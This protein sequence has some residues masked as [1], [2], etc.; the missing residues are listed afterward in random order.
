MEN[1]KDVEENEADRLTSSNSAKEGHPLLAD[2]TTNNSFTNATEPSQ[3]P[4]DISRFYFP[5]ALEGIDTLAKVAAVT[6]RLGMNGPNTLYAQSVCPDEINHEPGDITHLFSTHYGEVFHMGGLAGLP[7]TGKTGFGAFSHHVPKDG[8]CLILMAPHIGI[9]ESNILG[10]YTRDGQ[11]GEGAACGAAVAA[12]HHCACGKPAPSLDDPLDYQ[13]SFL[14]SIIQENK[15]HILQESLSHNEK[16]AALAL[17]VW[18]VS[19]RMLENIVNVNFGGDESKLLIF[20]G[21]Q[22]NMPRPHQDMF[23]PLSFN[24]YTKDGQVTDLFEEAFGYSRAENQ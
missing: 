21:I 8:H 6:R 14:T 15:S 9:T 11:D 10:A 19:K 3:S 12:L 24:M 22:I 23:Q 20:S 5:G 13:Q 17:E 4:R 2:E 1:K 18:K 7:F 16:M